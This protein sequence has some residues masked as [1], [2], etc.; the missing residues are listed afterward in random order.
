MYVPAISLSERF[1]TSGVISI[2]FDRKTVEG[3]EG[4]VSGTIV[5]I[6]ELKIDFEAVRVS[7]KPDHAP[8]YRYGS[9][10]RVSG[11]VWQQD[12]RNKLGEVVHSFDDYVNISLACKPARPQF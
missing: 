3:L 6:T 2:D 10:D 1:R 12:W 11:A 5:K 4:V 9:I 7:P 8:V